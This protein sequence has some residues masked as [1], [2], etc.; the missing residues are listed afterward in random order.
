MSDKKGSYEMNNFKGGGDGED[1][2]GE[3][4]TE[5][6]LPDRGQWVGKLDFLMSCV[7]YAIGLGNVWRFP[8]LCYKNGG[9]RDR[10]L[11][12]ERLLAQIR[13]QV[14]IDMPVHAGVS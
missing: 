10:I 4:S 6:A 5:P 9:V 1:P 8:Y 13:N 7:G 11:Y 14:R 2:A 12:W 3:V